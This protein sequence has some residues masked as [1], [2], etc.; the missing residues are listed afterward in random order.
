MTTVNEHKA[1]RCPLSPEKSTPNSSAAELNKET[2]ANESRNFILTLIFMA[3]CVS[4]SLPVSFRFF[5]LL[6]RLVFIL[7]LF[8]LMSVSVRVCVWVGGFDFC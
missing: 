4:V 1:H 8:I 2:D 3:V 7:L 5:F 6:F